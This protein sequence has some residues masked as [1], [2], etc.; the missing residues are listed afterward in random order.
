[1]YPDLTQAA[2]GLAELDD[3]DSPEGDVDLAARFVYGVAV[4]VLAGMA[5]V[6]LSAGVVLGYLAA[7]GEGYA[8]GAGQGFQDG[9]KAA[10]V[11]LVQPH[12]N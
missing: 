2:R 6:L 7:Q 8:R 11:E 9:Y 4:S 10:S 5:V 12:R 3:W 1:M